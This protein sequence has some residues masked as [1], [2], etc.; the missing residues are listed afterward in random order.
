M[1][2]RS[3]WKLLAVLLAF[4][5]LAAACGDDDDDTS[6]GD[7]TT[8]DGSADGSSDDSAD[9]SD[10]S[11]DSSDDSADSSDDS[12]DSSD[13]SADSA[14]DSTDDGADDGEMAA[15]CDATVPGTQ[16]N[17]GQ[18]SPAAII[19]APYASGSLVGGTELLAVYDA[20]LRYNPETDDYDPQLAESLTPNDD[21]TEWTLVLQE[22]LTFSNGDPFDIENLFASMDR[23]FNEGVRNSS[24]GWL[25]LIEDRQEVDE[26]TA[27]FTLSKPWS[28]FG[29]VF[30]DEPG[31]VINTRVIPEGEDDFAA[32]Q[33]SPLPEAGMGPYV[34]TRNVPG[35]ELVMTARDDYWGGPVCIE[36]LRFVFVPGAAGT[37][38]AFQA[39]DL[40]VGFIR[41]ANVY[42]TAVENGEQIISDR[43][44][45]GGITLMNHREGAA[46]SDPRLR[47]AIILAI[48]ENVISER[49]YSGDLKTTRALFSEDSRFY[50]DDI[51][52]SDYDP[53]RAATLVEEAKADGFDG[54]ITIVQSQDGAG[55]DISLAVEGMLEAVGF[56]V[57]V[58]LVP[59]IDSITRVVQADYDLVPT[60]G[61]S[62]GSAETYTQI[63]FNLSGTSPSNR[64]GY[65]SDAMDAAIDAML[66][67]PDAD[68][69]VA[70]MAEINRVFVEEFVGLNYAALDVGIV[71]APNVQGIKAT[72][73]V[74]YM[75][76]DAYIAE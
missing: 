11:A 15:A 32:F 72:G 29:Y 75:F 57:T 1:R 48:D 61:F 43:Q 6:A 68:A 41:D 63:L 40:D 73:T 71:V 27:V 74:M 55:P 62:L 44:E 24:A 2:Q 7:D 5:L 33:A 13:D 64:M 42:A 8:A 35:E 23:F 56:D 18:F 34:V 60:W 37:Y 28:T 12:A 31:M 59:L 46:L 26:R 66:A 19:D 54:A 53:D 21:F 22:G 25:A 39:G 14:D 65:A 10:D 47:E 17:Y 3:I 58:D 9:S 52:Q 76:D 51:I 50:S 45:S 20:L 49:G 36:T 67:A 30:A 38:D 16:V 70:A 69:R 4:S